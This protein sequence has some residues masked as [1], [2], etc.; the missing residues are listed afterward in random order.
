MKNKMK[1]KLFDR[2]RLQVQLRAVINTWGTEGYEII[3]AALEREIQYEQ[4]CK[5]LQHS[6]SADA[7]RLHHKQTS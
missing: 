1:N 6:D 3:A 7:D 2:L 4:H 5:D